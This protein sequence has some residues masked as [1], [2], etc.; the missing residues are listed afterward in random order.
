MNLAFA[1]RLCGAAFW[2]T[3][4]ALLAG[5][6]ARASDKSDAEAL[7]ENARVT[8]QAF[9]QN[10]D[11]ASLK[12][13]LGRARAV[14]IFPEVLKAG[15]LLGGFGGS[16]V[17]L[18]RDQATGAWHGPAFY[19]MG[20]ASFGLQA[21]A[22]AAEI[23]MVVGSQKAL[24]SLYTNKLKL[25][26]DA[27]VALGPKGMGTGAAIDADF[28]VYAKTRGVFAG[29]AVDG[30]VMDVR[31]TLNA[32]YYGRPASPLEILVRKTVSRADAAALQSAVAAAAR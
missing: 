9:A 6:Q 27:S 20:G 24:D 32:A 3:I 30:S 2:L 11:F 21:G 12:S 18:A 22:S 31:D 14:L 29:L 1:G 7:A 23:V 17:L 10:P 26:G 28:V 13:A 4:A 5:P 25:G 15:L 16:G 19:T 8:I